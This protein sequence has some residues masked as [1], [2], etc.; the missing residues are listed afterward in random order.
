[1]IIH[2]FIL[3]I[4]L[5][6]VIMSAKNSLVMEL[7]SLSGVKL[8]SSGISLTLGKPLSREIPSKRSSDRP[9]VYAGHEDE[10]YF[11]RQQEFLSRPELRVAP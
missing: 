10:L 4:F 7:L 8:E 6:I 5:L 11:S 9:L 2:L 1:M 3:L